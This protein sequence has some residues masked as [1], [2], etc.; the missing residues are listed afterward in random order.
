[1][2][3]VHIVWDTHV[4]GLVN[5]AMLCGMFA[6]AVVL[7]RR[8]MKRIQDGIDQVVLAKI[9][10]DTAAKISE[11]TDNRL[12]EGTTAAANNAAAVVS[13]EHLQRSIAV[14]AAAVS[15][16]PAKVTEEIQK[17][18]ASES[19]HLLS[20]VNVTADTVNVTPKG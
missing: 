9:H 20:T 5:F 10:A 4:I 18:A 19:G 3:P 2:P 6:I 13:A 17:Q 12:A 11:R 15:D 14:V 8:V 1:M 16:L 7:H